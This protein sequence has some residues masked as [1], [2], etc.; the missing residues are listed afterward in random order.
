MQERRKLASVVSAGNSEFLLGNGVFLYS[1]AERRNKMKSQNIGL[2]F[3]GYNS[4]YL[5]IF[6][7]NVVAIFLR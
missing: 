5:S 4:I 7:A 2:N 3:K 1:L 6:C